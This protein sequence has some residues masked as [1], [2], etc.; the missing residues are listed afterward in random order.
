MSVLEVLIPFQEI[1]VRN[2][3]YSEPQWLSDM[4]R[5]RKICSRMHGGE[6]VQDYSRD[7]RRWIRKSEKKSRRSEEIKFKTNYIMVGRRISGQQLKWHKTNLKTK[8]QR[9]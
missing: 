8:Y 4:K 2:N 6:D 5:K 9:K 7:A 1:K 3:K